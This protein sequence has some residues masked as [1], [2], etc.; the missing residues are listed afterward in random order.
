[1]KKVVVVE[2]ETM[3]KI[4]EIKL[5]GKREAHKTQFGIIDTKNN[6]ELVASLVDNFHKL[7]VNKE[8]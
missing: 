4:D 1:M 3:R 7:F 8:K 6:K 2:Q 5:A